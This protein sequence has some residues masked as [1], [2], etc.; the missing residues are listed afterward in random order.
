V[1]RAVPN[2]ATPFAILLNPD[3][4]VH[5][6]DTSA[7]VSAMVARHAALAAPNIVDPA[8]EP[9][10]CAGERQSFRD[11]LRR[12]AGRP[13]RVKVAR[14]LDPT[15]VQHVG[16]VSGACCL[17]DIAA[18]RSVGGFDPNIF[19]YYEDM[20]LGRRF[21]RAGWE[22]LRVGHGT[23]VHEGGATFKSS[24]RRRFRIYYS[25]LLYMRTARH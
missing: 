20:E 4:V 6:W 23:C 22:I 9:E 21:H 15:E 24:L 5:D 8:G 16:W 11:I 2:I 14:N 3:A 25:L 7:T 19:M 18:F 1:N 10:P 12:L 13:S 17:V